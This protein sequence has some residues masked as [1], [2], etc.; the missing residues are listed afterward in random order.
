[1]KYIF[2]IG[3]A[4]QFASTVIPAI[5]AETQLSAPS[6]LTQPTTQKPEPRSAPVSERSQNNSARRELTQPDDK[7]QLLERDRLI[8]ERYLIRV[9]PKTSG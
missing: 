8:L 4:L 5:S 1:M 9:I 2:G 3:I 6:S 7:T